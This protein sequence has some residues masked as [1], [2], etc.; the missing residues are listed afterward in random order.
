M[1]I[2]K[3]RNRFTPHSTKCVSAGG[4]FKSATDTYMR[5]AAMCS[6]VKTY[7]DGKLI[8]TEPALTSLEVSKVF[9]RN[10]YGR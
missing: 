6:E 10:S 9:N 3:P 7:K 5:S 2:N 4:V 1:R 8:K